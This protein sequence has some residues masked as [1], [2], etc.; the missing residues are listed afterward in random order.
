M[1]SSHRPPDPGSATP[2][3]QWRWS[4]SWRSEPRYSSCRCVTA[5]PAVLLEEDQL[6]PSPTDLVE[7]NPWE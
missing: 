6:P 7:G 2:R 1:A 3:D 5:L 4:D